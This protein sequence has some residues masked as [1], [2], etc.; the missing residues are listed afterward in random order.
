MFCSI[1]K[2]ITPDTLEKSVFDDVKL[3]T[4][5]CSKTTLIMAPVASIDAFKESKFVALS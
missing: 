5:K 3:I 1:S 2:E 4:D